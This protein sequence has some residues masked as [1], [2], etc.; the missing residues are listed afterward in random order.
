MSTHPL[1]H[2][3]VHTICAIC[4]KKKKKK[5][6]R[7]TGIQ[8]Q[9]IW[10]LI[11]STAAQHP[12]ILLR[13]PRWRKRIESEEPADWCRPTAAEH[14]FW[15]LPGKKK[16][17]STAFHCFRFMKRA[18]QSFRN[19]CDLP[20]QKHGFYI[21]VKG[22]M[23]RENMGPTSELSSH[24]ARRRSQSLASGTNSAPC[25]LPLI[26]Y[27]GLLLLQSCCDVSGFIPG[28]AKIGTWAFFSSRIFLLAYPPL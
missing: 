1:I 13:S 15:G 21:K 7:G 12:L 27:W 25:S 18:R 5:K 3:S 24:I 28:E 22:R 19:V 16:E 2:R 9:D 4:C 14:L 23:G 11:K 26:Q 6:S 20:W 17:N 8:P 10:F